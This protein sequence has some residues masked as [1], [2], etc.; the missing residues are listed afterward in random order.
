MWTVFG[1]MMGIEPVTLHLKIRRADFQIV[2]RAWM[3]C[4]LKSLNI[5]RNA[6]FNNLSGSSGITVHCNMYTVGPEIVDQHNFELVHFSISLNRELWDWVPLQNTK[7]T[8]I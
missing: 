1:R 3:R 2:T 7:C 4:K 5:F 6:F 8:E